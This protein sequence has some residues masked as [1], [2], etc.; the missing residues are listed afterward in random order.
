[1]PFCAGMPLLY[2]NKVTFREVGLDP[3][4]PPQDLEEVR[5]Y[6]E[7]ILKRDARRERGAQ[8]H[9]HRHPGLDGAHPGR[10]RRPL[11]GQRQRA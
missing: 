6:S 5:Q 3:E 1:M 11:R 2:Y 4:K 8:R 7:K 9:R 10:A